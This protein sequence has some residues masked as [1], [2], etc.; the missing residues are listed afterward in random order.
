MSIKSTCPKNIVLQQ[1]LCKP[2]SSSAFFLSSPLPI[3]SVYDS[4]KCAIGLPQLP[5]ADRYNHRSFPPRSKT[6]EPL[7]VIVIFPPT[8][9][10]FARGFLPVRAC[11]A[12]QAL[13]SLHRRQASFCHNLKILPLACHF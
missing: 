5:T 3:L 1:Y 10:I 7:L 6:F 12:L 13:S 4:H 8:C 11:L 9:T 2:S